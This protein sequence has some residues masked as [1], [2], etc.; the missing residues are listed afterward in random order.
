MS[1]VRVRWHKLERC[2][3]NRSDVDAIPS[4]RNVVVVALKGIGMRDTVVIPEDCCRVRSS[5]VTRPVLN[6]LEHNFGITVREIMS[7]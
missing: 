7:S 6:Q 4:G 1:K 3:K 2:I 5:E